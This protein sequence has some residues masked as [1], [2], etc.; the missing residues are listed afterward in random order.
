MIVASFG[1]N[2]AELYAG[3]QSTNI[4]QCDDYKK[5]IFL[6]GSLKAHMYHNSAETARRLAY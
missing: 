1:H 2:Y 5:W 3:S 6:L 4:T